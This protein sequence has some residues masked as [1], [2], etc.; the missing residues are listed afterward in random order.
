MQAFFIFPLQLS[1]FSP[2]RER[3]HLEIFSNSRPIRPPAHFS[4]T[5]SRR[6]EQSMAFEEA[7]FPGGQTS[8]VSHQMLV[9]IAPVCPFISP[10]FCA[11]SRPSFSLKKV[12]ES[13]LLI[14][15]FTQTHRGKHR[16]RRSLPFSRQI[17]SIKSLFPHFG[18]ILVLERHILSLGHILLQIRSLN[19]GL[20]C[21]LL[22]HFP[23]LPPFTLA[24]FPRFHAPYLAGS[25][26][27]S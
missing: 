17:F 2:N 1:L 9:S 26:F 11:K 6:G 15:Q 10:S 16:D 21:H 19:V 22:L 24:S 12:L 25:F 5:F 3:W 20:G 23:I 27:A 18:G 14:E 13:L 7:V 8:S 4:L